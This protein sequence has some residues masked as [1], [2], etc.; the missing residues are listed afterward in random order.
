MRREPYASIFFSILQR[1][2]LPPNDY[3]DLAVLAS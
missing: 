3:E 1:K 2:V